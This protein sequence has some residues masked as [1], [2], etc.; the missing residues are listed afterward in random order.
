[1]R[2]FHHVL[3][4]A[5]LSVL[6]GTAGAETVGIVDEFH[7][8]ARGRSMVALEDR[9][10]KALWEVVGPVGDITCGDGVLSLQG[11]PRT[12]IRLFSKT[13][14]KYGVMTARLR[15]DTVG[16][17]FN[18]YAGFANK[19]PWASAI[20]WIQHT[21]SGNGILLAGRD[22]TL[23]GQ[24][25][26]IQTGEFKPG[27]FH[28]VK[29]VWEPEKVELFVDGVS[30]G[31]IS[32]KPAIPQQALPVLFAVY[33][34]DQPYSMSIDR[35][36]VVGGKDDSAGA[37]PPQS[38]TPV[39]MPQTP[40]P[41]ACPTPPEAPAA[42]RNAESRLIC[43]NRFYRMEFDT[44]NG[45]ELREFFSKYLQKNLLRSSSAFFM[46]H[47]QDRRLDPAQFA[48]TAI[49]LDRFGADGRKAVIS[50]HNP[51]EKLHA[52]M[53]LAVQPDAPELSV[54]FTIVNAADLVRRLGVTVPLLTGLQIG[55]TVA[56][57]EF[58]YPFES[59]AAG[60]LDCELRHS[61][62]CT[63]FMP[64][65]SVYNPAAGG[66]VYTY[67]R[68]KNGYPNILMLRKQSTEQF[69]GVRYD[70]VPF[71]FG[72]GQNP[73]GV[74]PET[75]GTSLGVRHIEFQLGG[76]ARGS[77]TPA[78]VGVHLGNWHEPLRRYA[79]FA[80]RNWFSKRVRTPRWYMDCYGLLSAHPYSGLHLLHQPESFG[81]FDRA[82]GDYCYARQ[83]TSRERNVVMEFAGIFDYDPQTDAMTLDEVN[84]AGLPVINAYSK[85]NYNYNRSRGG[86]PLLRREVAQ[87]QK[88]GGRF[89]FYTWPQACARGTELDLKYGGKWARMRSPERYDEDYTADGMGWN[90]CAYEQEFGE[91]IS[92]KYAQI[93]EQ[94]HADGYRLDVFSRI[95]P[96]YN[97]RHSHYD[98]TLRG[99]MA[100]EAAG[101]VL[102]CFIESAR[103]V[104]PEAAVTVEHAASDYLAQFH[105]GFFS[106]NIIWMGDQG[107]WEPYRALNMYGL[108]FSRFYFPEIKT[109]IHG[110]ADR[111]LALRMSLFNAVGYAC[112]DPRAVTAIHTLAENGDA[113]NYG[114]P[115]TPYVPT[116]KKQVFANHFPGENKQIWCI[117]NRS[118][119]AS[120]KTPL[121]AVPSR[122]G[123]HYVELYRDETVPV[124]GGGP[125]PTLA[126]NE[127]GVVAELPEILECKIDSGFLHIQ[128]R[129]QNP[130]ELELEVLYD[131]DDYSLERRTLN[132]IGG[133]AQLPL[134]GGNSKI[135]V[136]LYQNNYLLDEVILNR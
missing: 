38:V 72:R 12:E 7:T 67:I 35:V 55:P 135:I 57:D 25:D 40:L 11:K 73:V 125:A 15:Y 3:Y 65:L 97:P 21:D 29:I 47:D 89:M 32:E 130:D 76:G 113:F 110:P 100:P 118:A 103:R 33:S 82:T 128:V 85:G 102:S 127:V 4:V 120:E 81:F 93:L 121:L 124:I 115:P 30:K 46:V 37:P 64:L 123:Y 60:D 22:K 95:A 117:W 114:L 66:G 48:V 78:V 68:E 9:S 133:H 16:R 105:D 28:T 80:R 106:E 94:T 61:Y 88:N 126:P 5:L 13:R 45:L 39:S 92:R 52:E 108:V 101:K 91:I 74:F 1:M 83:V 18:L 70:V 104:N 98:G 86:L 26:A 99:T 34:S 50:L 6:I 84:D 119:Q 19:D 79:D 63:A 23:P 112:S 8:F 109:W 134:P 62:G 43:E 14:F 17:G 136:K 71:D 2:F 51:Q 107:M 75:P 131:R 122:A 111:E 27:V 54:D 59:G 10:E 42:I 116:L 58:F 24:I 77:V 132:S 56:G 49:K 31:F 90:F 53:T 69:K 87:I 96:C 41:A 20:A 44:R 36:E 129:A